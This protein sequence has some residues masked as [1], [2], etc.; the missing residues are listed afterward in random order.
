M[1]TNEMPKIN[2][3]IYVPADELAEMRRVMC[4]DAAGPA[5]LALSR[6]GLAAEKAK[7]E[8]ANGK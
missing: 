3:G 7:E 1:N 2:V 8:A 5:V 4:V 6:K